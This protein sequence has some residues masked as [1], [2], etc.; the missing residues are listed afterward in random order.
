MSALPPVSSSPSAPSAPP[1]SLARTPPR[2]V[3]TLTQV[4][5]PQ[6]LPEPAALAEPSKSPVL[7]VQPSP[8]AHL[9][10]AQN[11]QQLQQRVV[12]H[13]L[14]QMDATLERSMREVVSAVALSHANEIAQD[15]RPAIETTVKAMVEQAV[16]AALAE[17]LGDKTGFKTNMAS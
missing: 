1:Q 13:V 2:F 7:L 4:V 17:A 14:H 8:T 10:M 11:L 3:P 6:E 15:L 16:S 5:V 12:D 9:L